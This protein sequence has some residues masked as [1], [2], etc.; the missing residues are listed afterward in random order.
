MAPKSTDWTDQ[1]IHQY[2][3]TLEEPLKQQFE[4]R[5]QRIDDVYTRRMMLREAEIPAAFKETNKPFH[6]PLIFD[7]LRSVVAL[8]AKSYP[9]PKVVPQ[10]PGQK[11]QETSSKI[12]EWLTAAYKRMAVRE[13]IYPLIVDALAADGGGA[14]KIVLRK[15]EWLSRRQKN[16]SNAE[17]LERIDSLR[18][19]QFPFHWEHIP[20]ASYFPS[21][22]EEG[23]ATVLTIQSRVSIDIAKRFRLLPDSSGNLVKVG[24]DT[25]NPFPSSVE[26]KELWTRDHYAYLVGDEVMQSG[27]HSY[28]EVPFFNA[29]S[30][31]CSSGKPA[32]QGISLAYPLI[33]IQDQIEDIM[34]GK[35]NWGWLN[36]YPTWKLKPLG[37]DAMLPANYKIERVSGEAFVPPSGFDAGW[38]G[39][40]PVGAE[41]NDMLIRILQ[42]AESLSLAPI[43]RAN[44][45]SSEMSGVTAAMM[46]TIAQTQFGIAVDNL[47][48]SFNQMAGFM[49]RRIEKNLKKPV[50]LW[51]KDKDKWEELGPEDING[52][53]EVEHTL[54]PVV[55]AIKQIKYTWL[56]QAQQVGV[57]SMRYLRE[58]GVN[59]S[60]PEK[61][62]EE[63]NTEVLFNRPE[64]QN[65]LVQRLLEDMGA[66]NQ[67]PQAPGTSLAPSGGPGGLGQPALAGAQR[68]LPPTG[69][70]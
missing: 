33:S 7:Y 59:L 26:Y 4:K 36:F 31:V 1:L 63:V 44:V 32:D 52:Y 27:K 15:D 12:E 41:I 50:P 18:Y 9:I 13:N 14:W 55:E 8:M 43:L 48:R 10:K 3:E 68:P 47:A 20:T 34:T 57:V 65:L 46:V 62:E 51:K 30:S 40:P 35:S 53:Y 58:E 19:K 2:L 45:P 38:E 25:A 37:E 61:M 69:G 70:P 11:A 28:G 54:E 22:D 24:G 42:M 39:A 64:I 56:Q 6:S 5:E 49:L 21:Y 16:E 23:L 66:A 17:Y 67:Q 29:V 60:S